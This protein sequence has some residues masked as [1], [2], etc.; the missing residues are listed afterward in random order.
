VQPEK[1]IY[2]EITHVFTTSRAA[3]KKAAVFTTAARVLAFIGT[4]N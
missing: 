3:Q 1:N 4:I 2:R